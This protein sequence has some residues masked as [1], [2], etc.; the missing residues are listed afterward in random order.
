MTDYVQ[1][2]ADFIQL[3]ADAGLALHIA[4]Q[5]PTATVMPIKPTDED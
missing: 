1:K 3:C 4:G 5:G 2:F